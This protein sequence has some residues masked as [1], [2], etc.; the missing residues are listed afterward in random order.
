MSN[1][2][3][4]RREMV[5]FAEMAM[6]ELVSDLHRLSGVR[7]GSADVL[8]GVALD[9]FLVAMEA[10]ESAHTKVDGDM[11]AESKR[12]LS[13]AADITLRVETVKGEVMDTLTSL[14]GVKCQPDHYTAEDLAAMRRAHAETRAKV[15]EFLAPRLASAA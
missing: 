6:T 1:D 4:L 15:A 2:K 5:A 14:V 11:F 8:S 10:I 7:R 13:D 3:A 12:L 9:K